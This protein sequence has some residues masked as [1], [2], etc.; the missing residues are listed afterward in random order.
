MKL[1]EN[2]TLEELTHSDV[3][4][5]FK[6]KNEPNEEQKDNLKR[7]CTD[8]LQPIRE[9]YGFPIT[10]TSGYRNVN[11]NNKVKGSKT[12]QHIKGQAA[13]ITC[14]DTTKAFLFDLIKKMIEEGKIKVGQLIWEY[15]TKKE[16]KWIHVS[17][18]Y[19]KTNQILY[20]YSK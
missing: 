11:V 10:V 7:L 13:D 15:G 6:I 19:T 2:F 1:S 17:L 12:S 20:F 16:P 3:A 18:P 8:I 9:E 14:N 5:K 4:T